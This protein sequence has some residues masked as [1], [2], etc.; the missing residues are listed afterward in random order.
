PPLGGEGP[1]PP[2]ERGALDELEELRCRPSTR[3]EAAHHPSQLEPQLRHPVVVIYHPIT[4]ILNELKGGECTCVEDIIITAG[5]AS[6]ATRTGSS[7]ST[8][9]RPNA[10]NSKRSSST[11]K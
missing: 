7:G 11:C 9:C 5:A 4:I 10:H 1:V 8:G 2:A 3:P 6:A